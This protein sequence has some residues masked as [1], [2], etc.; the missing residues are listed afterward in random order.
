MWG[1]VDKITQSLD[2]LGALDKVTTD[3]LLTLFTNKLGAV[4][5]R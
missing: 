2:A 5:I 4:A 3:R 1:R